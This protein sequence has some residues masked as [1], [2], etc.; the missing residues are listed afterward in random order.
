MGYDLSHGEGLN[1]GKGHC[2][3]LQPFVPK[4]KLANYYNQGRRGLGYVTPP[5]MF[6]S[7]VESDYCPL[8]HSSES[9]NWDSN[10]TVGA[11]FKDLSV[12]MTLIC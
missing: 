6:D 9:S 12:N 3:P 10:V 4:G 5:T 1:F 7:E 8:S 11:A 2:I